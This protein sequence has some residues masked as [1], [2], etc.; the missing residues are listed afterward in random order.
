MIR[1]EEKR[2][3]SEPKAGKHVG[4]QEWI[5]IKEMGWGP[6]KRGSGADM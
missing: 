4:R 3:K 2:V 5:R 6:N 1:E